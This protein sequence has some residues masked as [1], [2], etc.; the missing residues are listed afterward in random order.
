[1]ATAAQAQNP[2]GPPPPVRPPSPRPTSQVIQRVWIPDTHDYK[3]ARRYVQ[4]RE[5]ER[6]P[7]TSDRG[8]RLGWCYICGKY[9]Y[10][11]NMEVD[12]VVPEN[13][14]RALLKLRGENQSMAEDIAEALQLDWKTTKEYDFEKTYDAYSG[15]R[16]RYENV[17]RTSKHAFSGNLY[18]ALYDVKNLKLICRSCN[19]KSVKTNKLLTVDYD[20]LQVE[21]KKWNKSGRTLIKKYL[22]AWIE[23]DYELDHNDVDMNYGSP[24]NSPGYTTPTTYRL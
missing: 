11:N 7:K 22:S 1:M 8:H 14:L 15:Y 20:A 21:Y 5:Y 17:D 24:P 3:N 13:F 10:M 4:W 9:D 23:T 6:D 12:H 18:E 19:G 16:E 2:Q